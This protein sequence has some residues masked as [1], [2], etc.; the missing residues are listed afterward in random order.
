MKKIA[1]LCQKSEIGKQLNGAIAVHISALEKLPPLLRLY[2]GCA[3]PISTVWKMPILSN[4]ITTS[5]K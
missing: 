4:F 3:S 2:E 1:N 5:Q